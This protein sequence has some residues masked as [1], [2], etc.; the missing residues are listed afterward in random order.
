[1]R[2]QH[3]PSSALL[4]EKLFHIWE[5]LF[6]DLLEALHSEDPLPCSTISTNVDPNGL[7][8]FWRRSSQRI[9]PTRLAPSSRQARAGLAPILLQL[10][11]L[12]DQL[13][14]WLSQLKQLLH[15]TTC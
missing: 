13:L 1:L 3:S 4:K 9:F 6:T 2:S 7:P 11:L 8:T 5:K 10:Q 12:L 15:L 14:E